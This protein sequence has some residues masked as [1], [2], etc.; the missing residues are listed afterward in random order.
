MDSMPIGDR[1][2]EIAYA[3]PWSQARWRAG[4][5]PNQ[6]EM[7]AVMDTTGCRDYREH[8]SGETAVSSRVEPLLERCWPSVIALAQKLLRD[9]E[10]RNEDVCAALQIP[11][12]DNEHHLSLIRSGC[13]PGSFAVTRPVGV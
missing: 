6:R 5:R 1:A 2:A 11:A 9:G 8:L 7:W 4:R 13:A 3:G 12:K 10:A